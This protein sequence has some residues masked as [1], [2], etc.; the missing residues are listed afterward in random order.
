MEI[1]SRNL[2]KKIPIKTRQV[3]LIVK[4]LLSLLKID[5]AVI[6]IIFVSRQKMQ[7]YNK[8]YLGRAYLTDV[9]AFEGDAQMWPAV[10]PPEKTPLE[11]IGDIVVCPEVAI[12]QSQFFETTLA[13]EIGLYVVHGILHLFGYD[14]HSVQDKK[15]MREKETELMTKVKGRWAKIL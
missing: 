13:D 10:H 8:K 11:L 1:T 12:K 2:Q 14:D 3:E 6:S 4:R 15:R 5:H 9:I 7:A